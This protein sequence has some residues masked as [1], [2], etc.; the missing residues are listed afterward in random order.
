MARIISP[1]LGAELKQLYA[2]LPAAYQRA[3]AALRTDPPGHLL[4]GESL[5]RFLAADAAASTIVRRIKEI[6]GE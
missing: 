5:A 1:E 6:Q 4:E 3:A 2:E